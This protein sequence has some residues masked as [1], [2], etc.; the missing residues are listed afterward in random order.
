MML[1]ALGTMGRAS[2][3]AVCG[4]M[5]FSAAAEP[6]VVT[7]EVSKDG[8]FATVT[9]NRPDVHNALS[10]ALIAQLTESVRS[11]ADKDSD[12]RALFLRAEGKTFC[13]GGDLKHMRSTGDYTH[14]ENEAEALVLSGLFEEVRSF[15]RPVIAL[16]GGPCY[17][18]G[19]GLISACDMAF[20]LPTCK[21]VLSEVKLGVIP[22][23]ISPFVLA[24]IGASAA[25]RY[26]LTA[27]MFDAAEAKHIGLLHDVVEDLDEHRQHLEKALNMCSPR[28]LGGS[29]EL[30]DQVAN[31]PIDDSLRK[32]TATRLADVRE[33]ADGQEGMSAFIEKRKPSWLRD[34]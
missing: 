21:F 3:S 32:W 13:A 15:P 10:P 24:R 23:T 2:R 12:L 7:T 9:L 19:V 5:A 30:I 29:K 14:E 22:A 27:E 1:R 28:A 31:R 34:D 33:S 25:S 18:G 16:V 4:R 11:L 20:A 26:F 17:G 6:S 8:K